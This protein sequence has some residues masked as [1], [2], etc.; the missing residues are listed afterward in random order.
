MNFKIYKKVSLAIISCGF[1]VISSCGPNTTNDDNK[2]NTSEAGTHTD[3]THNG[4]EGT[5][6]QAATLSSDNK[7][8]TSSG[9][10]A[11]G[12]GSAKGGTQK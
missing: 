12:S 2:P 3:T 6:D 10:K 8:D 11:P 1:L 4:L 9:Q 5:R 7:M